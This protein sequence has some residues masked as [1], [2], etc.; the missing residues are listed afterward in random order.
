MKR[1]SDCPLCLLNS[2]TKFTRAALARSTFI[3]ISLLGRNYGPPVLAGISLNEGISAPPA[4]FDSDSVTFNSPRA[5]EVSIYLKRDIQNLNQMLHSVLS[6]SLFSR[7]CH[8]Q[9]LNR[10]NGV[11]MS[12][13]DVLFNHGQGQ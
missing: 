11:L 6:L 12:L 1:I 9:S 5:A 8:L 3:I 13:F 7:P 2:E 4:S 10:F